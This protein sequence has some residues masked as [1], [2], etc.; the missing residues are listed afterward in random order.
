MNKL[1][2]T[3]LILAAAIVLVS[4]NR[5]AYGQCQVDDIGIVGDVMVDGRVGL[6]DLGVV[7]SY[8]MKSGE[9]LAGD[10]SNDDR[11]GVD[12]LV[13]LAGNWMCGCD[14]I[15][16]FSMYSYSVY[17]TCNA[18]VADASINNFD[19]ET[20]GYFREY[21]DELE[22]TGVIEMARPGALQNC[23]EPEYCSTIVLTEVEKK[24]IHAA[25]T[26]HSVWLDKNEM[27]PWTIRGYSDRELSGLFGEDKLFNHNGAQYS[28]FSVVDHSPSEAYSYALELELIGDDALSSFYSVVTDLRMDF[29]H[30]NT[31]DENRN[32]AYTL[33]EA[34][35]TYAAN[36]RRVSRR[37]CHSM[38]RI[39][40]GL[41]RS[42]N[43]P[44]EETTAGVWYEMGHS[45]GV[46]PTLERVLPHGDHIYNALV[47][48]TPVVEF[49]PTFTFYD[50]NVGVEPCGES[51]VC[52]SHRHMSLNA[53]AYPSDWTLRR[54]CDPA[55]YGYESCQEYIYDSHSAY[56]SLEEMDA[57]VIVLEGVCGGSATTKTVDISR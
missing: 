50:N 28:Y 42:I 10:I 35:S 41:L 1:S 13:M 55:G 19:E 5:Q 7:A 29:R 25:K 38:T 36:D 21:I 26:A 22:E 34:L 32:T 15:E 40:I 6:K 54:S 48:A 30:G 23:N 24:R 56:L 31:G 18:N 46:W 45:S 39:A 51:T 47:R 33:K 57:A 16:S 9:G 11:V 44:G 52:L 53:V 4:V 2:F 49:L 43:I 12:D 17:F 14:D 27:L 20:A 37:G 8:W 3:L